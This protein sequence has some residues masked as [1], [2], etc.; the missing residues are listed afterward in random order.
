MKRVKLGVALK[1]PSEVA[2][3]VIAIFGC[4]IINF[5]LNLSIIDVSIF[6]GKVKSRKP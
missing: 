4:Q 2:I 1:F 3:S 5:N 6:L